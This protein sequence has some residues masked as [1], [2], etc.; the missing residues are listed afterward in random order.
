LTPGTVIAKGD[1]DATI[2][3]RARKTFGVIPS[4]AD[5]QLF[6]VV[7]NIDARLMRVEQ[8][9]P[10]LASR[11]ELVAALAPLANREEMRTAI[12]EAVA[13]LATRDEMH[14]AIQAAVVTLA[15][16]EEMHAAIHAAVAPLATRDEMHAA[17]KSLADQ[18]RV[19]IK[20]EGERSRQYTNVLF[21][22][23]RDD[24]QL[25]LE[26]LIAL[27]VRVDAIAQR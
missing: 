17:L 4:M 24:T 10:N 26:H 14:A 15:T 20:E 21:E 23:I 6:E 3:R 9:L 11:D 22:D 5:E 16:R 25:I 19:E 8:I 7:R 1:D 27:S 13:P 2:S 18:L 12:Q